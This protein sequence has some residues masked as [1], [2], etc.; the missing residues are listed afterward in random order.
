VRRAKGRAQPTRKVAQIVDRI[1]TWSWCP[2]TN[3]MFWSQET[4]RILGLGRRRASPSLEMLFDAIERSERPFIEEAF[5]SAVR[6]KGDFDHEFTIVRPDRS[7]RHIHCLANPAL[8]RSGKV[9]E[10]VGAIRD[11][12]ARWAAE[13]AMRATRAELARVSRVLRMGAL[14]A[15]IAHEVSQPLAAVITNGNAG[16]RWLKGTKPRLDKARKALTGIVRD[17]R[18]ASEV[19]GRIRALARRGT[20]PERRTLNVNSI[21]RGIAALTR[22]EVHASGAMLRLRLAKELPSVSGDA[23]QLEQVILNLIMNGIEAMTVADRPKELIITT[24]REEDGGIR[25]TVCDTGVGFD[26]QSPER[27][28]EPFYTTKAQGMGIG[29]ALSRAVVAEHGGRLWAVKNAE[30]GATFSFILP[31]A[32]NG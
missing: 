8:A 2:A 12:T 21:V 3:E 1:G 4:F 18:R 10:Y 27:L 29:L 7:S 23:V 31:R 9:A 30:H 16:L 22:A 26:H 15:C 11:I 14:A 6:E 32:G 13:E 5:R 20:Q 28:F 19:I 24:R 25:V 17:G